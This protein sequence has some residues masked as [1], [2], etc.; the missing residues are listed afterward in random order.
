[1]Q[2]N[3]IHLLQQGKQGGDIDMHFFMAI[4]AVFFY[5]NDKNSFKFDQ[6]VNN[7]N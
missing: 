7:K 2:K 4:C 5:H 1:M 6:K 3:T